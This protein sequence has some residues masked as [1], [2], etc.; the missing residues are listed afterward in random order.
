MKELRAKLKGRTWADFGKH[1]YIII[2]GI[3]FHGRVGYLLNRPVFAIK[4]DDIIVA[5]KDPGFEKVTR[6]FYAR[7]VIATDDCTD[8]T[9]SIA[10]QIRNWDGIKND[11]GAIVD[12]GDEND[13]G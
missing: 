6:P 1:A 11:S 10:R 4:V 3:T 5:V 8:E 7:R 9:G 13:P 12:D 2:D